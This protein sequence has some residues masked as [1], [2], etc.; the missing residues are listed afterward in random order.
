M[1]GFEFTFFA[2]VLNDISFSTD[3]LFDIPCIILLH[4]F[5]A[6]AYSI[7]IVYVCNLIRGHRIKITHRRRA[8]PVSI[9]PLIADAI[10]ER[11]QA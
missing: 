7:H 11:I 1:N 2:V 8:Y 5:V 6:R 4:T 10:K 9:V 3:R